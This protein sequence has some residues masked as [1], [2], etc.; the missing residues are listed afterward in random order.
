MPAYLALFVGLGFFEDPEPGIIDGLITS[1]LIATFLCDSGRNLKRRLVL[2]AGGIA[3]LAVG[4]GLIWFL[5]GDNSTPSPLEWMKFRYAL[6]WIALLA[7]ASDLPDGLPPLPTI[8]LLAVLLLAFTMWQFLG[9]ADSFDPPQ[10]ARVFFREM[11]LYT[12]LSLLIAMVWKQGLHLLRP[13]A[14]VA[15]ILAA[16]SYTHLTLPTNREV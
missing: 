4:L 2:V 1:L 8:R 13:A 10:S 12:L 15:M 5:A 9:I 3:G 14:G 11:G 16:V 7:V 6:Q